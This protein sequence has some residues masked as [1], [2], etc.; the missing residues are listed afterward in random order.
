[1]NKENIS[2]VYLLSTPLDSNY[3]N[4]L[5][6]ASK[7]SQ[8][9]Y[10]QSVIKKSYTGFTYLRKDNLIYVP[11]HIDN[12]YDANYVMYQNTYY[13]DKWF[14]AFIKD[15]KYESDECTII[16]IEKYFPEGLA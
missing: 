3:K 8:Q 15:M 6:F 7:E 2:K 1:M 4:T 12:I 9:T 10:F 13:K 11:D 5:Y 14:Y 16:E